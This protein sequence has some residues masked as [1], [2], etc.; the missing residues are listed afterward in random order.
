MLEQSLCSCAAK[1]LMKNKL[2]W[3]RWESNG[4][5]VKTEE[6][7]LNEFLSIHTLIYLQHMSEYIYN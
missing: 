6:R 7:K 5:I 4:I 1:V 2:F 3:A